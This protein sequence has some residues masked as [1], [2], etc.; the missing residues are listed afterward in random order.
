M[1]V[2]RTNRPVGCE[3]ILKADA[4]SAAPACGAGRGET[5]S[6]QCVK[7]GEG[8]IGD[9]C[10]ALDV[11]QCC[12]PRP[13]ELGREKADA[14]RFH[15]GGECRIEYADARIAEV[16]PVALRFQSEH[17][18]AGSLP[19]I[20]DLPTEKASGAISAAIAKHW[21]SERYEVPAV[22]AVAPAAVDADV[23]AAPV[24]DH[25][26]WRGGGGWRL[27]RH[28]G[29]KRRRCEPDGDANCCQYYSH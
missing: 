7:D 15:A 22:V 11:E 2:F 26:N 9:G 5:N 20:A 13:P 16:G 21:P 12:V 19:T 18:L 3:A 14:V 25:R 6:C 17:K 28:V 4:E 10:A 8:I 23:E 1:V 24:V 27:D 29:R